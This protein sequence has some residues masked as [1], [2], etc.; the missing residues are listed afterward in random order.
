M[1][2][3]EIFV[4]ACGRRNLFYTPACLVPGGEARDFS[5][6]CTDADDTDALC[7]RGDAGGN[8]FVRKTNLLNI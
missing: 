6:A 2:Q 4:G 3:Q 8:A 7:R 5:A 1:R